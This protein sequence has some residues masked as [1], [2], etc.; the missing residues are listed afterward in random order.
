MYCPR[1]G[2]LLVSKNGT[3][4]CV[5]GNMELSKRVAEDLHCSFLTESQQPF[6]HAYKNSFHVG[7]KWFCPRCG[8]AM[9]EESSGEIR[10][11]QCSR[12]IAK[13]IYQ[14]VE[15]NP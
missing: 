2:E 7:G 9:Q 1:C 10:F 4:F 6:D 8:V 13:Y 5:K 12:N 14:L 15:L 11:P 3:Y